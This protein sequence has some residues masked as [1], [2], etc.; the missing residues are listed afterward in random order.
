MRSTAGDSRMNGARIRSPSVVCTLMCSN[1]SPVSGPG[2]FRMASRVPI[3]P[4]SWSS[5]PSRICSSGS[6]AQTELRRRLHRV[7]AHPGGVTAGVGILGFERVH[8]HL[9]A[10]DERL[11]VAA[12]ELPHPALEVLL[13]KAVLPDQIPLLERLL[14]PG[15]HLV[16]QHRLREVVQRADLETF[17]RRTD[18]GHAG[19]HDDGHVGVEPERFAKE[20]HSVHLG[21]VDVRDADRDLAF[22]LQQRQRLGAG[23]GLSAGQALRFDHAGKRAADLRVVVHDE[24]PRTSRGANGGC[25]HSREAT[26][27]ESNL[28]PRLPRSV[29]RRYA[30]A[31]CPQPARPALGRTP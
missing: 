21:H 3:L 22:G 5:P 29:E 25:G 9:H 7:A 17:H 15:A 11:L 24:T 2:L 16:D 6:P 13:V 1:S 28:Q 18:L 31:T 26:R 4:M 14:H 23:A 10:V 8:Q 27:D 19:E 12:V 30:S 20:G